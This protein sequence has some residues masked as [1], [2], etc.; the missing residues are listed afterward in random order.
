MPFKSISGDR[1]CQGPDG[2]LATELIRIVSDSKT[3]KTYSANDASL[4]TAM[5][6]STSVWSGNRFHLICP[7]WSTNCKF[8]NAVW[9]RVWGCIWNRNPDWLLMSAVGEGSWGGSRCA[10]H[11]LLATL[12]SISWTTLHDD[13]STI[14]L[15]SSHHVSTHSRI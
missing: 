5:Y 13:G 3:C 9:T 8:Q 1:L 12:A 11:L 10:A 14:F 2:D 6:I 4:T 7:F 15:H